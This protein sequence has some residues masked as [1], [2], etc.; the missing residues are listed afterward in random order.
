MEINFIDAIPEDKPHC[1][2]C[3][4]FDEEDH[5]KLFQLCAEKE[6]NVPSFGLCPKWK[7]KTANNQLINS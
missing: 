6:E 5:E 7:K 1:G 3:F 4:F 2:N